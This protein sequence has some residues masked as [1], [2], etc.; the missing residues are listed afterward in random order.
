MLEQSAECVSCCA[1]KLFYEKLFNLYSLKNWPD[2]RPTFGVSVVTGVEMH[3]HD[4]AS[5]RS[6]SSQ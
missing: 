6:V 2:E 4:T 1:E 5:R 3:M